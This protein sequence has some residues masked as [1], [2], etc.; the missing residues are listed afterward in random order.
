MINNDMIEKDVYSL[1]ETKTNKIWV[2]KPVYRKIIKGTDF[3]ENKDIAIP[4]NIANLETVIS[5][6]G[7]FLDTS[8]R[9]IP[10]NLYNSGSPKY[11]T[12]GFIW[13]KSIY[14]KCLVN[15]KAVTFII[16]YTKTTD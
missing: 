11:N 15:F 1:E 6:E 3:T 7:F 4:L 16:E 12:I 5:I 2:N 13:N 9:Q 14:Y 10:I 8:N